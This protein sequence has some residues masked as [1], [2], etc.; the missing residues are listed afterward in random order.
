[1]QES[2]FD[3]LCGLQQTDISQAMC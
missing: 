2:Q 1:M 3:K